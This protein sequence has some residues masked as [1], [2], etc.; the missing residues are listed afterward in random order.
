MQRHLLPLL[1]RRH[2]ELERARR[3]L[4][5]GGGGLCRLCPGGQR[6]TLRLFLA[7]DALQSRAQ[8]GRRAQRVVALVG[9]PLG[10]GQG[11]L[12]VLLRLEQLRA[13]PLQLL[14]RRVARGG[15]ASRRRLDRRHVRPQLAHLTDEAHLVL[16]AASALLPQPLELVGRQPR[17]RRQHVVLLVQ[18]ID[19]RSELSRLERAGAVEG[20]PL[21]GLGVERLTAHRRLESRLQ[22]RLERSDPRGSVLSVTTRAHMGVALK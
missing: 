16:D 5:R 10:D 3:L 1:R 17:L 7:A 15:R 6:P 2:L 4:L 8:L 13:A 12:R 11:G 22:L 19:P 9:V 14:A 21:D 18:H 20:L